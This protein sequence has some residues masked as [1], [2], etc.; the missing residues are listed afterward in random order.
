MDPARGT[1]LL[2][3]GIEL[4]IFGGVLVLASSGSA[5]AIGVI[6]AV[7]GLFV[8]LSGLTTVDK[9]AAPPS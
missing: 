2:L 9:A 4:T 7:V 1:K 5:G 3:F 8:G 6:L